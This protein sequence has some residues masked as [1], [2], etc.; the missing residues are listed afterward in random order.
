MK[1]EN[2][3][4]NR[5]DGTVVFNN[6]PVPYGNWRNF[7]GMPTKFNPTNTARYFHIFLTDEEA[8]RLED[9]GWNSGR[10]ERREDRS[11]WMLI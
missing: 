11:L 8:Q 9:L 10:Q 7:A 5:E 4:I 1:K 3:T 2:M 6:A